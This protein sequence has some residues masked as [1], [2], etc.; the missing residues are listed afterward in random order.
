METARTTFL[1]EMGP[2][3]IIGRRK[4]FMKSKPVLFMTITENHDA[5]AFG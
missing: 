1:R 2:D 5:T 3:G 4:S